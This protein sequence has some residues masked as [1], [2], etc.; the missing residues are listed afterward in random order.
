MNKNTIAKA[1]SAILALLLCVGVFAILAQFT[2]NFNEEFKTFYVTYNGKDIFAKESKMYFAP[3]EEHVFDVTYT[4][5]FLDEGEEAK[6]DYSVKI[7]PNVDKET[8]FTFTVEGEEVNYSSVGELTKGFGLKK[9]ETSFTLTIAE[10]TTLESVLE[11]VYGK[12]VEAPSDDT[13][14][15]PRLYTLVISSYDESVTY[16]IDFS[17]S[18]WIE[19]DK[20]EIVF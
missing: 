16:K 6:T 17:I 13:F 4:F 11:A 9:D 10:D 14:E 19:L 12:D 1:L 2:N 20:T 18:M 3:G 8:D 7:M 5:E 15:N